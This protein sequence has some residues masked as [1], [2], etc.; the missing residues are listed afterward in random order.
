MW[1]GELVERPL[2]RALALLIYQRPETAGREFFEIAGP[3]KS[4]VPDLFA[5]GRCG[6]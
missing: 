4:E 2:P 6:V 5:P 3:F 1:L